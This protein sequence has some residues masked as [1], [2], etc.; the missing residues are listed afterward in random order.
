MDETRTAAAEAVPAPSPQ[1]APLRPA[2]P[3]QAPPPAPAAA[4]AP[5]DALVEQWWSDHFPGS[6]VAQVTA[7][8]N[9]AFAA[10]EDLK[11][12]LRKGI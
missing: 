12:R 11:Q 2:A 9:V 10:K 5:T 4:P 7:A 1:P 6:A 3:G 8:W